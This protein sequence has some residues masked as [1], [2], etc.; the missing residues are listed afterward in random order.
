MFTISFDYDQ[1][2]HYVWQFS[3]DGGTT[4][5]TIAPVVVS[6]SGGSANSYN[7]TVAPSFFAVGLRW[8]PV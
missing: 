7:Q 8:L 3:P 2:K 4:W 1:N 6:P 5:V